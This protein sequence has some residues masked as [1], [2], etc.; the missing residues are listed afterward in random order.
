MSR[1]ALLLCL[2]PV[3]GMGCAAAPDASRFATRAIQA[4]D[5]D[6]VFAAAIPI[7]RREFGRIDVDRSGRWIEATRVY[8]ADDQSNT[9]RDLVRAPSTLRQNALMH[10]RRSGDTAVAEIR[11]DIQR[12]DTERRRM[13]MSSPT[14]LTDRPSSTP[15]DRDAATTTK[16]NEVWTN[17]RRDRPLERSL[18]EELAEWAARRQETQQTGG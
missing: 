10:V 16:Q 6:A 13:M 4:A 12:R 11:V 8:S 14:R 18:L 17:V 9:A 3:V 1:S 2:I 15:I 7:M 5:Q